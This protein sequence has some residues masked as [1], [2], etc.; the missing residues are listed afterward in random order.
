MSDLHDST[1]VRNLDDTAVIRNF[2]H[3]FP[4]FGKYTFDQLFDINEVQKIQD[5]FSK[6]TGVASIITDIDGT[7]ITKPSGFSFFCNEI[8]RKT[9][10]GSCNCMKSDAILGAPHSGGPRMQ[11]CLSGGLLDGGTSIMVGSHHVANWLI[12]QILDEEIDINEMYKYCFEIGADFDIYKEALEKVTKMPKERFLDICNFLYLNA[13]MLSSQAVKNIVQQE[14]IIKRKR[15]EDALRLSEE[16]YRLLTEFASDVIWVLNLTKNRFTYISPSIY[17]L[18]GFTV[19]EALQETLEESLTPHSFPI[20][21]AHLEKGVKELIDNPDNQN[22]YVSEIQQPC[23]NGEV[24]WTEVSTKFRKNADGEIEVVG[25]S[26][27]IEKRKTA[28]AEILYLSYRDQLTGLANR[29]FY[30]DELKRIDNTKNMP[31]AL[32]MIDVNG[33]KLTNDAFSHNFGDLLL[34]KAA[35]ILKSVCRASDTAC[36]IGGDEFVLLLPCCSAEAADHI[37]TRITKAIASEKLENI[38]LSASI[39]YAV[40]D[41]V[42]QNISDI[43]REAEDRMYKNK[44]DES[45]GMRSKTIEIIMSTLYEKYNREMLHSKRVS[46][47]C[48][49]IAVG[50]NFSRD[51]IDQIRTAGLMHD[52]GKIGIDEQILNKPGKLTSSEWYEIHKHAEIGYRI[53]SSV[54]E[55]SAIAEYDLAHHE[56]WDGQGYPKG[57]RAE[58]IPVKAR[59]ISIAD[60]YDAMTTN[61]TYMNVLSIEEAVCEI[62][63]CS[64]TQFDP[65]IARIFVENILGMTWER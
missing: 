43:F 37:V 42:S 62:K 61:R 48:E 45:S 58:E 50:M 64:G 55:F 8:I 31:L 44:L 33:L 34:I 49:A 65:D 30:E 22:S 38:I 26:R 3:I 57:L 23:K 41:N 29:R 4:A 60:S 21:A 39:G 7:P 19:D 35:N 46:E 47:L 16:K 10:K 15:T 6:A 28:E 11:R 13:M 40:K 52:I 54:N 20:A 18:R 5:A 51:D 12:G 53:L 59:I 9:E 32:I 27:N 24:I 63:N 14:E 36:R 56:R 17:Q 1:S 25:V 2:K